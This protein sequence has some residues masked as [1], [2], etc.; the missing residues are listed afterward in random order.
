MSVYNYFTNVANNVFT[1]QLQTK[2][3]TLKINYYRYKTKHKLN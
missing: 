2:I 1:R 3:N